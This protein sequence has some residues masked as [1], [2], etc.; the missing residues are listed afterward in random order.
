MEEH[1]QATINMIDHSTLLQGKDLRE[2]S[3]IK[4]FNLKKYKN[5]S[6]ATWTLNLRYDI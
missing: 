2:F 3:Q 4:M 5:K 6:N 1:Q